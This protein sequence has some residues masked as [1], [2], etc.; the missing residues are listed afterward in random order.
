[1]KKIYILS[2][3]KKWIK[4]WFEDGTWSKENTTSVVI[5]KENGKYIQV[6]GSGEKGSYDYL[7]KHTLELV[8]DSSLR[9]IGYGEF[10]GYSDT[11]ERNVT[12]YVFK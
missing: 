12:T 11:I 7:K 10:I 8:S 1:M 6:F 4:E 2:T 5:R 9:T 3:P